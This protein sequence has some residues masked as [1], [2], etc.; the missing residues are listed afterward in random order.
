MIDA[1]PD[2]QAWDRIADTYS[3]MIGT[4]D[5]RMYALFRD[6]LW[7][8][9]GDLQ[10]RRVLDLGCG[11]GWLSAAM[12]AAGASVCGIDGSTELLNKARSVCPQG[13]FLEWDLSQGLPPFAQKFDRVVSYMVLMDIPELDALLRAVRSVLQ[14]E[15][16]KFIFTMT[17]PCFFNYK[18]H[19]DAENDQHYCKVTGYLKPETWWIE[20]FGGHCHY[21]R[22][23]TEYFEALCT[24]GLA[25][26]RFYEPPQA[27]PGT[28]DEN[29][30]RYEIP[31][32]LLVE[33]VP[34]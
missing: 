7:D 11:H 14:E 5:D 17:H 21:H 30:F 32:F 29:D 13:E 31:K 2:I 15:T 33:A 27:L 22:S 23:L 24:S 18:S 26:T 9:L 19:Y 20:T 34:V 10:G 1:K 4:P 28:A 3:Q 16:G 8:S 12:F 6:V 25:V